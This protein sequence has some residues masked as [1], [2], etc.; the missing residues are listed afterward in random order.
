MDGRDRLPTYRIR[1]EGH[2]DD[3]LAAWPDGTSVTRE[4]DGATVLTVPL[5]D[6]AALLG[7]LRTLRDVGARLVS[8]N[9]AAPGRAG[10]E[11]REEDQ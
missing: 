11:S 6:Q 2:L 5:L 7:L 4:D 8:I 10:N 1:V 3:R 9:P